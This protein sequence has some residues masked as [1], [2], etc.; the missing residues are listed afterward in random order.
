M[1]KIVQTWFDNLFDVEFQLP[2]D[3]FVDVVATQHEYI[4]AF[5]DSPTKTSLTF[6]IETTAKKLIKR[7]IDDV[8]MLFSY[9]RFPLKTLSSRM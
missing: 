1:N 9:P 6:H 5:E 7:K 4:R 2:G 3:G 8:L